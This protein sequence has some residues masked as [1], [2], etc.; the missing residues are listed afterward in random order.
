MNMI[1]AIIINFDPSSADRRFPL[2]APLR[3]WIC[4]AIWNGKYLDRLMLNLLRCCHF[5]VWPSLSR[6]DITLS[7]YCT[8]WRVK[9]KSQSENVWVL[10]KY[11]DCPNTAVKK[12]CNIF[13]SRLSPLSFSFSILFA[14]LWFLHFG[15]C[16]YPQRRYLWAQYQKSLKCQCQGVL[17]IV[18]WNNRFLVLLNDRVL[19]RSVKVLKDVF[20][21]CSAFNSRREYIVFSWVRG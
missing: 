20:I 16:S 15:C 1:L 21:S 18:W 13:I 4:S 2:C 9:K 7:C 5:T 11:S 10:N 17:T 3:W 12:T 8:C 14:I 19:W 6:Q